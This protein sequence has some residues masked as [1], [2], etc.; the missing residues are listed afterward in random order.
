VLPYLAIVILV[1]GIAWR[2]HYDK[3]GWTSRSSQLYESRALKIGS[4]L[5]HFG[6]IL[7]FLGHIGG[8]VIPAS[9]TSKVGI[10][11]DMYHA[12]AVTLGGLAGLAAVLG[13]VILVTRRYSNKPV[14]AATTNGDT[15]MYVILLF[16]MA[17]GMIVTAMAIFA[18]SGAHNYRES[19][20][21]WFRSLFTLNPDVH[22]MAGAPLQ[23]H[24]HVLVALVLFAA[25][26]FTRLV[27]L[28][29]APLHYLFRPYIVYRSRDVQ[30]MAP[31]GRPRRGWAPVGTP[32]RQTTHR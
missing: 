23:F 32:D 8:L 20:S 5:F 9:W 11:D 30:V 13:V 27:H 29:S 25:L 6:L 12:V 17:F 19:V 16:T 14:Q 10:T 15:V 24:L 1:T 4:P 26:P 3:F 22:A 2:Y 21:P 18:G 31:T 28:F 7:V